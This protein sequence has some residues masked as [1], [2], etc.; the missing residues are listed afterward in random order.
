MDWFYT[1]LGFSCLLMAVLIGAIMTG[2]GYS[3]FFERKVSAWVQDRVGPNR[4]GPLG[5]LQPLADGVKFIFKEDMI[6]AHV[7]RTLFVLAPML[8][9]GIAMVGMAVIP[10]GGVY[11]PPGEIGPLSV[12]VAS[13][14]VGLLYLLAVGSLSVYGVVLGSWASNNKYAF[15]GGL[16]AAAQMLSYEVP[17]GMIILVLVLTSGEVRL[18]GIVAAQTEPLLGAASWLPDWIPN[19]YIFLHPLAFI[20]LFTTALAETN[21]APF[22][23]AECEQELV[24]G[25]HTEYGSMKFA[26]FFLGEYTHIIVASALICVLFFGGWHVPGLET[27]QT[28]LLGVIL[29]LGVMGAKVTACVFVFMWIRWTLPRFRFDQLMRRAWKVLVPLTMALVAITA[30]L[31]YFQLHNSIYALV[32]EVS[33][34]VVMGMILLLTPARVTGRQE[35]L[36]PA[37]A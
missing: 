28:S 35:H 14:D 7:D 21:R 10:W 30:I 29:Q 5:L 15:Y 37:G 25:F 2:V 4:A 24:A 1:Q 6:P 8:A 20:V 23:L 11:D 3:T 12:Q 26:L 34:I 22:D 9:F 16:R 32:A 13:I 36:V 27:V 33:L 18:E 19:W 31:V 17:M